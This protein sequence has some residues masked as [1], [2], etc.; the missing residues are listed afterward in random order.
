[1]GKST[2][3][4]RLNKELKKHSLP[5][6]R[7]VLERPALIVGGHVRAPLDFAFGHGDQ[8]V[9]ITQAWSFQRGTVDEVATEVKAWGYA[10]RRVQDG[11]NA[12]IQGR[13]TSLVLGDKV[14]VEVLL[15]EPRTPHQQEVFEEAV[16][17]FEE[18]GVVRYGEDDAPSLVNH[19]AELMAA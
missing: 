17:V 14:P 4:A 12:R 16:E 15:A 13:H 11:D 8:S 6:G 5:P 2:L 1:M 9:Q 18:L 19:V 10:L 3:V 7:V